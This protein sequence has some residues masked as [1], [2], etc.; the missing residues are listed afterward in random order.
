MFLCNKYIE[1]IES[2]IIYL[3]VNTAVITIIRSDKR[4]YLQ[5]LQH[6]V[7]VAKCEKKSGDDGSQADDLSQDEGLEMDG[8]EEQA[9]AD[10]KVAVE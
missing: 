8:D 3:K 2:F 4:L 5:V 7:S 10:K 6:K 1:F 9:L